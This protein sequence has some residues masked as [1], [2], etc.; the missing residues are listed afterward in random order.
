MQSS[1]KVYIV[2]HLTASRL[3]QIESTVALLS[4]DLPISVLT[5]VKQASTRGNQVRVSAI[6]LVPKT[7]AAIQKVQFRMCLAGPFDPSP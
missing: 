4:L 3:D 1:L 2:I 7:V 5:L 6:S